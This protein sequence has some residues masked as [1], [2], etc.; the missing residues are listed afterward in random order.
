MKESNKRPIF[1]K[2]CIYFGKEDNTCR[3]HP[4]VAAYITDNRDR[5]TI[6]FWPEVGAEDWCGDGVLRGERR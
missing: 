5:S 4:P 3:R 6:S 2:R 1:C